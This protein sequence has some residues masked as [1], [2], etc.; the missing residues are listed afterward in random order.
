MREIVP[1]NGANGRRISLR[2]SESA[3]ERVHN[4]GLISG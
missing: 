3:E 1:D 4:V 2:L